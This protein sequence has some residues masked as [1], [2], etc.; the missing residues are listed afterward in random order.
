MFKSVKSDKPVW[1][2]RFTYREVIK[3]VCSM[4]NQ[5]ISQIQ[6]L[7]KQCVLECY[8]NTAN[9]LRM[10]GTFFKSRR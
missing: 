6:S 8:F 5:F 2:L 10:D 4:E 7:R 3:P 9:K 1:Q